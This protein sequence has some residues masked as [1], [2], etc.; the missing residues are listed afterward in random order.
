[1]LPVK[2]MPNRYQCPVCSLEITLAT[3]TLPEKW[4][5]EDWRDPSLSPICHA[6]NKPMEAS[7]TG[8]GRGQ[9]AYAG[10]YFNA[11]VFVCRDSQRHMVSGYFVEVSKET[12][13]DLGRQ[14]M[15][16]W[17]QMQ[18]DVAEQLVQGTLLEAA[19]PATVTTKMGIAA[20]RENGLTVVDIEGLS[21]D[22]K[23]ECISEC[24]HLERMGLLHDVR[25]DESRIIYRMDPLLAEK[26]ADA[27]LFS[28][29]PRNPIKQ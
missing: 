16:N 18:E 17:R 5:E 3:D 7:N 13:D 6:C 24:R 15:F 29:L 20:K 14:A 2:G 1:M 12:Y 22:D 26:L 27:A 25:I 9:G 11:A 23:E 10:R 28:S 8:C 4:Y 19:D 21:A